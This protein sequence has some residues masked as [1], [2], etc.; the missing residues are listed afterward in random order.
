MRKKYLSALL[1]GALLFASAGTFTSCKDYDDDIAGLSEKVDQLAKDL[2]DLKTKVEVLGGVESIEFKDGQLI[3]HTTKGDVSANMPECTGVQ[4]V[5]LEG[6]TLY[7][8]GKVAG[9]VELNEDG[10]APVIEVRE[11]GKLYVNGKVMD[12][13]VG[14]K[15]TV[16]DNGETV[17]LTVV[18]QP[19]VELAKAGSAILSSIDLEGSGKFVGTDVNSI[20]WAKATIATPDWKGS[21][22]PVKLNDLLIGQIT[23]ETVQVTPA[24]YDL[25]AHKLTLVD[26]RGNEAPVKI[27]PV[28]NNVLSQ[29]EVPTR[30]NS[31]ENG[32]WVLSIEIDE[33]KV[34]A[35]NIASVF[36]YDPEKTP[37][38]NSSV[39]N[40]SLCVDGVP[41]TEYK[42]SIVTDCQAA[43]SL[44]AIIGLTNQNLLFVDAEGR[45]QNAKDEEIPV[46]ATTPL[47]INTNKDAEIYDYY[48]TIEETYKSLAEQYGIKITEDGKGIYV[49]A[50]AEG[51]KIGINAHV[52]N[53][54]GQVSPNT[55]NTNIILT[56]AG[57]EV[58]AET[59]A[60]TEHL[61]IPG[62]ATKVIR[63]NFGDGEEN[64]FAKFPAAVREAVRSGKADIVVKEAATQLGFLV[65]SVDNK[66]TP[67]FFKKNGTEW[68]PGSHDLLDLSYMELT[69]AGNIAED[70]TPGEY[71]LTFV[72]TTTGDGQGSDPVGNEILKVNIPVKVAVPAF[73]DI[74]KKD[75][76]WNEAGDTYSARIIIPASTT[77][78]TLR[79]SNAFAKNKYTNNGVNVSSIGIVFNS[80]DDNKGEIWP[81]DDTNATEFVTNGVKAITVGIN[82]DVK[83]N[84]DVV[85][86]KEKQALKI[87]E[88]VGM[89]AYYNVFDG[90]TETAGY[91]AFN[92]AF[93]VVS[94]PFTT[95]I[96]TALD[97]V[98][99]AY[100]IDGVAQENV[101]LTSDACILGGSGA[102]T[103]ESPYQGFIFTLNG[104]AF[105]VK[106]GQFAGMANADKL[107]IFDLQENV[108]GS[109]SSSWSSIKGNTVNVEFT[110]AQ[111]DNLGW[112]GKDDTT[113]YSLKFNGSW[114]TSTLNIKFVDAFGIAYERS[115]KVQK[116]K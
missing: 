60:T 45:V 84:K 90:V 61:I 38:A 4:E 77:D 52:M 99:A 81:I 80:V 5:K 15:V 73:E 47:V 96:I 78:A 56:I 22:G 28:K 103:A 63:V 72:A 25:A 97:G 69:V 46:N 39:M 93:T 70:A 20:Q 114:N 82:K 27:T 86:D 116:A 100:Y 14:D 29:T 101:I 88:L 66:F 16:V 13:A 59:L 23:T 7:V 64:I 18:G 33:T 87:N 108:S 44:S 55:A 9:E 36:N 34:N 79:Y 2:E 35:G 11:D 30:S 105:Y 62:E 91:D 50:G 102:G 12:I 94:K 98:A 76:N 48:Y 6:N 104:D 40:Y 37:T 89:C 74:F 75:A 110:D 53:V 113:P 58:G 10:T 95:Q 21:K 24:A 49:P 67:A 85:Y 112:S 19:S 83:L 57:T 54:L 17:T 65:E 106:P 92:K 71:Q 31:F 26:A 8:D 68:N 109:F 43:N 107:D 1:F 51:I 111:G 32:S 3:V 41:Y 115:I 42:F